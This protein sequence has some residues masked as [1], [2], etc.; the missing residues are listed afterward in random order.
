[1]GYEARQLEYEDVTV[2]TLD[3]HRGM[4]I[5]AEAH[6]HFFT[7]YW[8]PSVS[9]GGWL[10]ALSQLFQFFG[11]EPHR[12]TIYWWAT[13]EYEETSLE[14]LYGELS[15]LGP[16]TFEAEA[17][18]V[19]V[20][21][22]ARSLSLA[23]QVMPTR[24]AQWLVYPPLMRERGELVSILSEVLDSDF[25]RWLIAR[26]AAPEIKEISDP[27]QEMGSVLSNYKSDVKVPPGL[28]Q[29]SA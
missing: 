20:D 7:I 16:E 3:V 22:I 2:R 12:V 23:W 19:R 4:Q 18:L 26:T 17:G 21:L 14:E 11:D 1:M 29:G 9:L 10:E 8:T 15:R 24:E 25:I 13:R 27:L 6:P 28:Y 5:A